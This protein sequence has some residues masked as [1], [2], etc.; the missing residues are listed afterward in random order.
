METDFYLSISS[1]DSF[2]NFPSNTA[3]D[4]LLHLKQPLSLQGY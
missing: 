2:D 1:N 4:F 3:S